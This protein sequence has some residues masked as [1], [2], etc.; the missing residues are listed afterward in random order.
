MDWVTVLTFGIGGAIGALAVWVYVRSG[1]RVQLS[2]LQDLL[3]ERDRTIEEIRHSRDQLQSELAALRDR[4]NDETQ[5]RSSAEER[6]SRIPILEAQ[7]EKGVR[8]QSQ[9]LERT[10]E[11]REQV[12]RL[13]TELEEERSAAAD[14]LE[15][16]EDARKKL[17]NSFKALAS[18]ALSGN[19]KSFLELAQETLGRFQENARGELDKRQQAIHQ[20]VKPVKESLDK[21]DV[22]VREIENARIGA[23]KSL[24]E[25]VKILA[26]SQNLLRSETSNLVRALRAP[27]V[28]GRWGE[29]QLK[30]VVEM[31]GMLEHCD[32]FQQESVSTEEGRLRPDLV[33]RLPG[34]KSIIVD[35]KAPLDAYLD[36]QEADT[37]Q[38]R[39]EKLREH[40]RRVRAHLK[41]L[42]LKAYWDQFE[43]VPEFVVLFLPGENFFSA[44]LEQD[45]GLIEA[46][47]DQ[48]VIIATP[49]TL[50]ALL[51]AV[52]Y[53]WRQE[54]LAENAQM[55]SDL[56]RELYKRIAAMAGHWARVGN[57]LST[58]VKNYNQAVGSLESR[59]LVSARRFKELE[60]VADS[61]EITSVEPVEH[62]VRRLSSEEFFE[63]KEREPD[64]NEVLSVGS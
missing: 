62:Q 36:A 34:R 48:K 15:L 51:R 18:E 8:E 52:A 29:I 64:G 7:I 10:A 41:A 63:E 43:F 49:T 32:F 26:E 55:I 11:L 2:A 53:G 3:Q 13:E 1:V 16:L 17:E 59:V 20:L 40:S 23:Y 46:G 31:A 42:S 56:G 24:S 57:G 60:A 12:S 54:V 47:V 27:V 9:L 35:A 58:A 22:R 14:K 45:P 37:E 30:R 6:S 61:S 33:V 38:L 44:A 5:K 4:L 21:F 19:S 25:Q 28:R 50:I 39:L